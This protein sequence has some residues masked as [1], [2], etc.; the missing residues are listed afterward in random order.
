MCVKLSPL[1]HVHFHI[2]EKFTGAD[3]LCCDVETFFNSLVA[4]HFVWLREK[5]KVAS[6]L[7]LQEQLYRDVTNFSV[8][9]VMCCFSVHNLVSIEMCVYL[10]SLKRSMFIHTFSVTVSL[11]LQGSTEASCGH[12]SACSHG[13]CFVDCYEIVAPHVTFCYGKIILL[14]LVCILAYK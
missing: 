5:Q 12:S 3:A 8:V 7:T 14:R 4:G 9:T 11:L 10:V 6:F 1:L 13:V 2:C